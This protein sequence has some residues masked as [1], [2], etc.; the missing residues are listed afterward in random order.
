MISYPSYTE[1]QM[2]LSMLVGIPEPTPPPQ[3]D[4]VGDFAANLLKQL[5]LELPT[6]PAG[7]QPTLV[8]AP[9]DMSLDTADRLHNE[10]SR[11]LEYADGALA[12]A[13]ARHMIVKGELDRVKA[14]FQFV[15]KKKDWSLLL[16]EEEFDKLQSLEQKAVELHATVVIISG[17]RDAINKVNAK[18]SRTITRHTKTNP[19]GF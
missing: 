4:T 5:G 10:A 7:G 19:A 11:W 1:D 3:T 2:A 15:H 14:Q 8:G 12:V 9:Q 17:V 13:E 6:R 16:S 18:A